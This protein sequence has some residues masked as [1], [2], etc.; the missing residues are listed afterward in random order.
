MGGGSEERH[1]RR[2]E[3]AAGGR[4]KKDEMKVE[5]GVKGLIGAVS[6][7][8]QK[9]KKILERTGLHG[10]LTQPRFISALNDAMGHQ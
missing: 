1:E 9:K 10:R 8:L 2:A 3:G 4:G 6:A 5:L 7:A